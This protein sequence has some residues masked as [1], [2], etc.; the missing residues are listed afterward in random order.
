MR[1]KQ[2]KRNGYRG[3]KTHGGGSM[4][5]RRGAGHRGGRG[6]AGSGK[7]ADTK[8][9]TLIN[10]YGNMK[11]YF[12]TQGFVSRFKKPKA[13]NI[14]TINNQLNK[15]IEKG[16]ATESKGKYAIN[17]KKAGYDKLLS[18]GKP[19]NVYEIDVDMASAKAIEKIE[20]AGG[21]V[22]L[23]TEKQLNEE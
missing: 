20:K 21:Q 7:R 18:V 3:S 14:Q 19:N 2:K 11:N 9:P 4:K 8:K 15:F 16:F 6:K 10:K 23:P 17:L 12:G 22:N 1:T 5:K 13:I